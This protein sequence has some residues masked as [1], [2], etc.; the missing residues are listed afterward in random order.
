MTAALLGWKQLGV[1]ALPGGADLS[2]TAHRGKGPALSWVTTI[3]PG[4]N[5]GRGAVV[6]DC[7]WALL[8]LVHPTMMEPRNAGSR[9]THRQSM[10]L[11]R[12]S[13]LD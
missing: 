6:R 11:E 13:R 2:R 12:R 9:R 7:G 10:L 3:R 1:A 5:N 8:S 4:R